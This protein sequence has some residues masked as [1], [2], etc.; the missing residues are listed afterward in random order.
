VAAEA[1]HGESDRV[2]ADRKPKAILVSIRILV[3]TDS[4][5]ALDRPCS[6]Q[7]PGSAAGLNRNDVS[8]LGVG[9]GAS[10]GDRAVRLGGRKGVV[11]WQFGFKIIGA[12]SRGTDP[13]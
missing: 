7:N 9:F 3:L 2:G 10:T 12:P 6:S 1:E 13:G 4:M 11:I 8:R 5:S